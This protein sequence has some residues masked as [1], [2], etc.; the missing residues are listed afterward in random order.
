MAKSASLKEIEN[1]VG[2]KNEILPCTDPRFRHSVRVIESDGTTFLIANAFLDTQGE[3]WVVVYAEH[4]SPRI[5]HKDDL[6]F[7]EEFET[8]KMID[9]RGGW[10]KTE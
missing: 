2:A 10:G 7:A 4:H 6:V 1:V 9:G 5:I 8:V 3:D